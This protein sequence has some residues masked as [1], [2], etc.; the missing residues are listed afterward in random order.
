MT[1]QLRFLYLIQGKATNIREY[2]FLREDKSDIFGI[3][4]DKP[5]PGFDYLPQSTFAS[6]RNYLYHFACNRIKDFDYFIFLDDDVDFSRGSFRQM[7]INL[8]RIRP[9]IGVPLTEKTRLTAI[10]LEIRRQIRPI[11]RQ[12]LL[13]FNDEQYLAMSSAVLQDGHILPYKTEW[14]NDSWFVCCLIQQALI[15]HYYFGQAFQFNDC[16]ISNNQHSG[17]YPH[18]LEFAQKTYLQWMK[19]HFPQGSKK[20]A[21]YP[22]TIR[23]D[24]NLRSSLQSLVSSV[25]AL[26]RRSRMYRRIRGTRKW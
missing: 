25:S 23:L 9:A 19:E 18:N 7:E 16:E 26:I 21:Y 15:Q 2:L 12:Q 11:V 4:Y 8:E 20:P 5:E 6:G 1:T 13:H 24:G 3:S 17:D 10:A 14:D 22:C